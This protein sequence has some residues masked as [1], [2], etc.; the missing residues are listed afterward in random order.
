MLN[1]LE[2]KNFTTVEHLSL[3]FDGGFTTITGETGAGKSVILDAISLIIGNRAQKNVL[4]DETKA[5]EVVASFD[6]QQ[7]SHCQQWLSVKELESPESDELII[8]RLLKPDGKSRAF[9]NGTAVNISDLKELGLQLIELHNQHEYQSLMDR[10]THQILLDIYSNATDEQQQ[11]AN[12]AKQ[13]LEINKKIIALETANTENTARVQ[14]LSYQ[15]NELEKLAPATNEYNTLESEFKILNN[16]EQLKSNLEE[17]LQICSD[18]GI[19]SQLQQLKIIIDTTREELPVLNN[20]SELIES[21]TIQIQEA[22]AELTH[23][24][25]Q[26]NLDPER[27]NQLQNRIDQLYTVARKHHIKPNDLEQLHTTLSEELKQLNNS[28][29]IIEELTIQRKK[30]E[31]DYQEVAVK[32]SKK[33]KD[34][35]KKL[36]KKVLGL[37]SELKMS[38]CNFDVAMSSSIPSDEKADTTITETLNSYGNE[39]IEF[40]IS[41][42]PGKPLQSLAKIASGGELSRISLAIQVATTSTSGKNKTT[43]T[44]IF[45]EVDV[46]IG[47]GVAE[48]VGKLLKDLGKNNQILCVTHLA[49]VAAKGD[50][51]LLVSKAVSKKTAETKI[52][53]LEKKE[54]KEELARMIGGVEITESTLAHASE[55]LET[56]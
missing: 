44:L 40:I 35:A 21:A 29:S 6:L 50:N 46:G 26:L 49:Q 41:T 9:I 36:G 8:R 15:V 19:L 45:D 52:K 28:D 31:K 48:V 25:D 38:H 16:A 39:K 1:H 53:A 5:C 51:H 33:R 54:R 47:G 43:P 18:E 22:S 13:W 4:R 34:G 27:L 42:I 55:M 7:H 11:V 32:L 37:L 30:I 20:C 56:A 12:F 3:E 23:A 24:T 10:R 2:I 17:S 14:L